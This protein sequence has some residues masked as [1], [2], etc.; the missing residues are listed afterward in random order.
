MQAHF[1]CLA[2]CVFVG[3]DVSVG[4]RRGCLGAFVCV[5]IQ[6]QDATRSMHT[7]GRP[8]QER[9]SHDLATD[10]RHTSMASSDT[11]RF[12]VIITKR[13]LFQSLAVVRYCP[14]CHGLPWPRDSSTVIWGQ[15]E[16]PRHHNSPSAII[17][18]MGSLC[19]HPIRKYHY[20][21]ADTN[22]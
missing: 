16:P 18:V 19:A 15:S 17:P 21:P 3:A 11:R 1:C 9:G 14:S 10:D 12:F 8:R 13:L 4:V 20:S 5:Q 7:Q 22:T 6:L 2:T